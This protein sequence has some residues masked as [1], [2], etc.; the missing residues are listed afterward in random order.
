[1]L[2][3]L[4]S[5]GDRRRDRRTGLATD[6]RGLPRTFDLQSGPQQA[7]GSDGTDI[8]AIELQAADVPENGECQG[9]VV[10]RLAG[11]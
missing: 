3:N 2:P 7:S 8:G 11:L 1:M 4:T 5:P 6:Q 9:A 10:R